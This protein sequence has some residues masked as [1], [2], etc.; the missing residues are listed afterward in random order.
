MKIRLSV[1]LLVAIATLIL[2]G[3]RSSAEKPNVV[4][5]M[6]DDVG[7]GDVSCYGAS[8][9][10]TPNIDRLASEGIRFTN[11][12]CSASNVYADSLFDVDGLLR[13]S[14]A[15]HWDRTTQFTGDY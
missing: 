2:P 11:G 10:K 13:V 8:A 14:K 3:A 4:V 6:A 1:V 7:F 12:H 9:V 5:I 15:G